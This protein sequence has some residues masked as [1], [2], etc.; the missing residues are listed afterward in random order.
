MSYHSA[1]FG[2][3][4][5]SLGGVVLLLVYHVISQDH[6]TKGSCDFMTKVW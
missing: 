4:S 6:V 1:K 3:D 5:Q 2:G